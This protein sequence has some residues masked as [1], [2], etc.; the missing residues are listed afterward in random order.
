[1]AAFQASAP[2]LVAVLLGV[3]AL[4]TLFPIRA[5]EAADRPSGG[6]GRPGRHFQSRRR[7][8]DS[9]R[10]RTLPSPTPRYLRTD[11]T[12]YVYTYEEEELRQAPQFS[13]SRDSFVATRV[14]TVR[15]ELR[16]ARA[17]GFAWFSLDRVSRLIAHDLEGVPLSASYLRVWDAEHDRINGMPVGTTSWVRLCGHGVVPRLAPPSLKVLVPGCVFLCRNSPPD[18]RLTESRRRFAIF[19]WHVR[20]AMLPGVTGMQFVPSLQALDMPGWGGVATASLNT[21]QTICPG[22]SNE[23]RFEWVLN[24]FRRVRRSYL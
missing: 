7:S 22:S 16:E 13:G 12:R 11:W 1:M 15:E 19:G 18:P 24:T 23:G 14:A 21:T 20:P 4:A 2:R 6:G 10:Q 5:G 9:A 17:R 8:P 3:V